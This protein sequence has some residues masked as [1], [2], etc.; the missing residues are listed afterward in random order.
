MA[1]VVLLVL[2]G[3]GILMCLAGAAWLVVDTRR[4]RAVRATDPGL[5]GS[6]GVALGMVLVGLSMVLVANLVALSR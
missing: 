6:R 3:I 2:G 5:G 1:D 4:L